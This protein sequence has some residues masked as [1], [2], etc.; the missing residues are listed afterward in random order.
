MVGLILAGD[1]ALV[2]TRLKVWGRGLA[3]EGRREGVYP[4]AGPPRY[5][6]S[7]RAVNGAHAARPARGAAGSLRGPGAERAPMCG[8]VVRS[9]VWESGAEVRPEA[10]RVLARAWRR[11]AGSP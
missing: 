8:A 1:S 3:R 10:L 6:G 11:T 5:G 9:Q 4:R 7:R 2:I